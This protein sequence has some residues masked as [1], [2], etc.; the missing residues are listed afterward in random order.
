MTITIQLLLLLL[1]VQLADKDNLG[2]VSRDILRVIYTEHFK[3]HGFGEELRAEEL[4]AVLDDS[5]IDSDD[6]TEMFQ[7]TARQK[8]RKQNPLGFIPVAIYDAKYISEVLVRACMRLYVYT[9]PVPVSLSLSLSTSLTPNTHTHTHYIPRYERW[10]GSNTTD[11][12]L[13][14]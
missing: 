3:K 8:Y 10:L 1:Q 6:Q 2:F 5:I 9:V 13:T 7:W 11:T 12:W 14:D 4:E